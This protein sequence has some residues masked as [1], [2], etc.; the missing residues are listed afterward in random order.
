[1]VIVWGIVI[2]VS[3]VLVFFNPFIGL[4]VFTAF[5]YVRPG[6]FSTFLAMTRPNLLLG[7]LTFLMVFIHKGRKGGII[8]FKAVPSKWFLVLGMVMCLSMAT[9][10]WRGNTYAFL[11]H[12]FKIYVAYFLIINLVSSLNHYRAIVWSMVMSMVY[13]G[14]MSIREYYLSGAAL[15]GGRMFGA[16]QGALFNDPND[17]A[18]GF[19]ILIPFLFFDLFRGKGLWRKMI[20]IGIIALFL[21]AIVLTQSRGGLIGLLVMLLML[22]FKSKYKVRLAVIG[23]IILAIG[24]QMAPQ[25]YRERMMTIQEAGEEDAAVISRM[26]AWQAGFNMMKDRVFGV[27][28]GNFGEGFVHYRPE[29]AVD[30][31]GTR[32]AAHNMFI[33]IGGETGFSGLFVFVMMI[34]SAF[35]VL[36]RIKKR[37][38]STVPIPPSRLGEM[39][40]IGLL[41]DAT[42]VSLVGYCASGM[43]LS[44]AYNFVL[45]YLIAF[46][47]VLENFTKFPGAQVPQSPAKKSKFFGNMGTGEPGNMRK[48]NRGSGDHGNLR[49]W[50]SRAMSVQLKKK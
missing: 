5:L 44:Q 9:S 29:G 6:M 21:W 18:L 17:L 22:W 27:G 2:F 48:G 45:Y 40:E 11:V 20:Q 46:A 7:V 41:A 8:F 4:Y 50:K 36:I 26:D 1:M 10:I 42:F 12:F 47:V 23:L 25:S 3:T 31:G 24:W 14:F 19:T 15:E 28:M 16:Y 30:P 32:R 43:F 39:K 35:R 37:P 34:A 33:E 38:S 49:K 13:I